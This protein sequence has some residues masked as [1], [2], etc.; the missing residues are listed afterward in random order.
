MKSLNSLKLYK[1]TKKEFSMNKIYSA[2]TLREIIGSLFNIDE[3][4][5]VFTKNDITDKVSNKVWRFNYIS[6]ISILKAFP[7][8]NIVNFA[9][10]DFEIAIRQFARDMSERGFKNP[11]ATGSNFLV[12]G[13]ENESDVIDSSTGGWPA[14]AFDPYKESSN[15][16]FGVIEKP[17]QKVFPIFDSLPE[18]ES[19][20]RKTEEFY[21]KKQT[22]VYFDLNNYLN[23]FAVSNYGVGFVNDDRLDNGVV[24]DLSECE[25]EDIIKF[26]DEISIQKTDD[27]DYCYYAGRFKKVSKGTIHT[28]FYTNRKDV[29]GYLVITKNGTNLVSAGGRNL[30]NIEIFKDFMREYYFGKFPSGEIKAIYVWDL[31]EKFAEFVRK[32]Y[33]QECSIGKAY[34]SLIYYIRTARFINN[35]YGLSV[36]ILTHKNDNSL[37]LVDNAEGGTPYD[38]DTLTFM[39][40]YGTC[41][42]FTDLKAEHSVDKTIPLDD[43]EVVYL[44][45]RNGLPKV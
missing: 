39:D 14:I 1:L 25:N 41:G 7:D 4:N 27:W 30:V 20:R 31:S 36:S 32:G 10:L 29:S 37:M 28:N 18:A 8:S 38:I 6:L 19:F 17:E 15:H 9:L 21:G 22:L 13:F 42:H 44:Y 40:R 45:F 11:I 12:I 34:Y 33:D 3:E 16:V 24:I 35:Q 43:G 23:P 26:S 5:K 2:K